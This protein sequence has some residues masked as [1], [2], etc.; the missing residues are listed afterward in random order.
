MPSEASAAAGVVRRAT[1]DGAVRS[2]AVATT[3]IGFALQAPVRVA[4]EA[5]AC[6]RSASAGDKTEMATVNM[7]HCTRVPGRGT[8]IRPLTGAKMP[9]HGAIKAERLYALPDQYPS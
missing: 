1:R 4:R 5:D 7:L 9:A 6:W 8:R 2:S 3:D